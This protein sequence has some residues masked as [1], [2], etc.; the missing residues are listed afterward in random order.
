[1]SKLTLADLARRFVGTD[2]ELREWLDV[3]C[4]PIAKPSPSQLA[5]WAEVDKKLAELGKPSN[6]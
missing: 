1:V 4:G 2:D 3:I 6:D 5:E